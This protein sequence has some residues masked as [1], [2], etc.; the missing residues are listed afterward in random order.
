MTDAQPFEA[1]GQRESD[2]KVIRDTNI[3]AFTGDRLTDI[4][5]THAVPNTTLFYRLSI[6]ANRRIT[7]AQRA[8][9]AQRVREAAGT[10]QESAGAP[11]SEDRPYRRIRNADVVGTGESGA[12]SEES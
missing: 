3:C 6:G 1:W 9:I 7:D 4:S 10:A 12:S 11:P 8:D 2:G 5:V